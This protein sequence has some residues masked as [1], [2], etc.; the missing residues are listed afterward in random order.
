MT[1]ASQ[2][3][4]PLRMCSFSNSS[5][6]L[7]FENWR[8]LIHLKHVH[9]M[10]LLSSFLCSEC[11]VLYST[12][13]YAERIIAQTGLQ[14]PSSAVL[15]KVAEELFQEFQGTGLDISQ[16]FFKKAHRW[17]VLNILW[18]FMAIFGFC[19]FD[20]L[21]QGMFFLPKEIYAK[22][23]KKEGRINPTLFLVYKLLDYQECVA[24]WIFRSVSYLDEL[25]NYTAR[26]YF[27]MNVRMTNGGTKRY[28]P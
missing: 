8:L 27:L 5:I 20:Y 21:K 19:M 17:L 24:S 18:L 23:R 16:P 6:L 25:M 2:D 11:W 13:E 14:K 26:T 4:L 7:D 9:S 1:A 10:L 28:R 22:K 3:A 15:T 12:P